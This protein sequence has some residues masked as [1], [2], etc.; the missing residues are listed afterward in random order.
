MTGHCLATKHLSDCS[1]R[2][3]CNRQTLPK[4]S[5]CSTHHQ[6]TEACYTQLEVFPNTVNADIT[7]QKGGPA[8]S[9][10]EQRKVNRLNLAEPL[11]VGLKRLHGS[12]ASTHNLT[13]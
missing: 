4:Q 8:C 1:T 10:C 12:S 6:Q 3:R 11:R 7:V 9:V 13:L 5:E 2:E